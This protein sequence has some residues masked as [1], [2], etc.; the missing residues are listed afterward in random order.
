MKNQNMGQEKGL[1]NSDPVPSRFV[2][3]SML[4]FCFLGF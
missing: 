1:L 2:N 4:A 3:S